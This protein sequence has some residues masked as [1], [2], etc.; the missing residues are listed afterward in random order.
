MKTKANLDAKAWAAANAGPRSARVCTACAN[1]ELRDFIHVVLIERAAGRSAATAQALHQKARD[2]FGYPHTYAALLAHLR[3]HE[4][5]LWNGG[6][7]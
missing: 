5:A 1:H 3:A 7:G 6:A 4:A 2:S